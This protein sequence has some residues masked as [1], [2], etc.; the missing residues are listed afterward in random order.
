MQQTLKLIVA[1]AIAA[2]A[3]G[4]AGTKIRGDFGEFIGRA[5][6][7]ATGKTPTDA[8]RRMEDQ[9]FA[10]ERREGINRL[11]AR[12]FGRGEPYT[13]RYQQIAQTD[14][15][16]LVRSTAIRALNRSR[17]AAATTIFIEGLSDP[18]VR[19]RLEAAKALANV[20]DEAAIPRLLQMVADDREDRDVRIAAADALR[21]HKR[22]EVAR[23]LISLLNQRDFAVAWQA[24]QSLKGITN[25]DFKYDEAAWLGLL[26][27]DQNPFG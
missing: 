20:P 2:G 8:A 12:S 11:S 22:V 27:S 3:L 14:S 23:G 9:Y 17:D 10:D 15:D 25:A 7:L 19:V 21:N 18:Q 6:D 5:G 4:C 16:Y 24:R 1:V 13:A 26:A